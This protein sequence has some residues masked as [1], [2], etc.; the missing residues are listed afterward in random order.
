[1]DGYTD[2][3]IQGVSCP[4]TEK[5]LFVT[6]VSLN[7]QDTFLLMS[8]CSLG[9]KTQIPAKSVTKMLLSEARASSRWVA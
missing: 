9:D 3:Q 4:N 2:R 1:M 5:Q 8:M 6:L 7:T